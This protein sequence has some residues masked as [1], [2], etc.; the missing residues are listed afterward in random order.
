MIIKVCG[1][2]EK[3]NHKAISAFDIEMIGLNFYRPSKRYLKNVTLPIMHGQKRVGVFVNEPIDSLRTM[4]ELHQ[5]DFAQLH[6]DEDEDYCSQIQ[7]FIPIIKVF[8]VDQNFDWRT[9]N[10]FEFAD[11]LLFDTM[12]SSYGGSGLKFDWSVLDNYKGA[13][14]FFLSG[15][16][17]PND[18]QAIKAIDHPLFI[19]ID[20]NSK[21]EISPGLKDVDLVNE[22]IERIRN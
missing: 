17:G 14:P 7:S 21:F 10:G 6:G 5:L 15:G 3:E 8:R 2:K 12:V 19:G 18:W 22:F 11:Y 1:I 9:T 13:T 20:I 16:L 4:V